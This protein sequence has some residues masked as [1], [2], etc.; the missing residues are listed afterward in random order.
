MSDA[1]SP[2]PSLRVACVPW[3]VDRVTSFEA[4][5]SRVRYFVE[6]A[7]ADYGAE[8]VL[9]PE[10]FTVPLLTTEAPME[11]MGGIRH[12]ARQFTEPFRE[13][14]AALAA[15]WGVYLVAGSHPVEQPDG[16]LRNVA[17]I[18]RPDGS[19]IDQPKLHIT[20][21]E[22]ETWNIAGGG[23]LAVIET[24][25]AR[26]GVLICYDVEFPEA[27]RALA[28]EGVEVLLVPYCTDNRQGW[29]R[30]TKCAAA[31]AV[32]SQ[33]YVATAGIVGSLDGVPGMNVHFGRSAVYT[34]SDFGFARDGIEAESE[35]NEEALLIAD[36]NLASLRRSRAAGTVTPI[37]DRRPDLFAFQ[38]QARIDR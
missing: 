10:F 24:P 21:W 28:D 3:R 38:S 31:R 8:V 29:L 2:S 27:V 12:L 1:E 5:V 18:F 11:A 13:R 36:L 20:P 34:P 25:K 16:S 9:F 33:I 35:A 17:M 7:R 37:N 26:L 4:F 32:E 22:T 23:S 6:T 19:R 30:V 14:M 15:E